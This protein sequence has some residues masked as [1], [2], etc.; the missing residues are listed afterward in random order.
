MKIAD[1]ENHFYTQ[2]KGSPWISNHEMKRE[3]TQL[4]FALK[5]TEQ[6][7]VYKHN[8]GTEQ[9]EIKLS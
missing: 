3:H 7:A 4:Q 6:I 5:L 8:N 9:K 1:N 2:G